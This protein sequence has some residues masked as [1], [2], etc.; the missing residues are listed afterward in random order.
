M[1]GLAAEQVDLITNKFVSMGVYEIPAKVD[2]YHEIALTELIHQHYDQIKAIVPEVLDIDFGFLGL[3]LGVK[4]QWN[5]FLK[6]D[7]SNTAEWL[8][9]LGLF[10][11][12]IIS[13]LLSY[14]SMK[15]SAK[16]NPQTP[17][18][19]ANT[20]S[21]MLTMPLISL[22]IGFV[23]PA[24]LGIY[25]ICSNVFTM[26]QD[27]MLTRH[28]NRILD[29]EEAERLEREKAKEAEIERK[30]QE[31]ERLRAQGA[32]TRNPNTSKRKIQAKQK[33][34]KEERIAS[35]KPKKDEGKP[36]SQVGDRP[37]A[38]GRAYDPDRFKKPGRAQEAAETAEVAEAESKEA[39]TMDLEANAT[40][41]APE[42]VNPAG[43][44][45]S[46]NEGE[47]VD[48]IESYQDDDSNDL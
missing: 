31:T 19:Q 12:P 11:I 16:T 47:N 23:M 42:T 8:P 7:W 35:K 46:Y 33:A 44:E 24:A 1:M 38:R 6:V 45:D 37:Y 13:A 39:P 4:P 29:I 36:A 17:D 3:D 22:W 20:K 5:F 26:I 25:W 40:G 28:Y 18:Q 15:I 9:A 14:L 21:M 41:S 2:A 34:L 32:S 30:R 10:L 43:F 48:H 27:M